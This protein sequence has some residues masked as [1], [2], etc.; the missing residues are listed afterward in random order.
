MLRESSKV[1]GTKIQ[2]KDITGGLSANTKV[3]GGEALLDLA[4]AIVAREEDRI[5][6]CRQKVH[7]LLGNS[8]VVDAV[9]VASAFHGFV[10][11]ADSIGIPYN[12][13][14]RGKDAA[15]IRD[16]AGINEF[17]RIKVLG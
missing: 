16:E 9:A 11:I 15:D 2:L 14:A 12:T 13:A 1:E 10:R 8:A 3:E 5:K 7:S 6:E 4:E 17:H